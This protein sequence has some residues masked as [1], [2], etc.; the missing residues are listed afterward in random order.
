[1]LGWILATLSIIG[2]I[3]NAQGRIDGFYLW[4]IANIGWMVYD[5]LTKQYSQLVLFFVYTITSIYGI[6]KW[7]KN[8]V[9]V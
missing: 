1:M 4:I 2:G 6:Y 5:V 3:R 7:K 9:K 8:I